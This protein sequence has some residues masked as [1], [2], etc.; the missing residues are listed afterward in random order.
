MIKCSVFCRITYPTARYRMPRRK[1]RQKTNMYRRYS[2]KLSYL[3][4]P[5]ILL[6]QVSFVAFYHGFTRLSLKFTLLTIHVLTDQAVGQPGKFKTH[7][8]IC[9]L[10]L[11][12]V[13]LRVSIFSIQSTREIPNIARPM[14]VYATLCLCKCHQSVHDSVLS[15]MIGQPQYTYENILLKPYFINLNIRYSQNQQVAYLLNKC[16]IV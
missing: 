13:I 7:I 3:K 5:S 14:A 6:V 1:Y 10:S 16:M 8:I 15:M 9:Q 2:A 4:N 11:N 12:F